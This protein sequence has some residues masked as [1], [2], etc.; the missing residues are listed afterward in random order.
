MQNPIDFSRRSRR[1]ILIFTVL[2]LTIVLIP[3]IYYLFSPPEK[4]TF[5]QTAFQEKRLKEYKF[6]DRERKTFSRKKSRFST[7]PCK[8]DPNTYTEENWIS[9][10]LSSK[11]AAIVLKFGRSGFYSAEDLKKVFVISDQFFEVIRDSLYYPARP[12]YDKSERKK[13]LARIEINTATEEELLTIKGIGAFF[14]KNIIKKR[15]ELGGFCEVGQLLEV[16]KFDQE[17]LD[18]IFPYIS[19]DPGLVRQISINQ[20]TAEELKT[21]PYISWNVANSIVKLRAQ[22]GSYQKI[23]DLRKSVLVTDELFEKLKPYLIL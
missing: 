18:V 21:H 7:P 12:S 15:N 3:R 17:K 6:K 1:A 13:N 4:F 20:A 10:G 19:I 9:L 22:I 11:Q 14:A 5:S 8:F 23:E 2:L 16:W